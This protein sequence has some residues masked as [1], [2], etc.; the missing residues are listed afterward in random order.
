V[1]PPRGVGQAGVGTRDM[2]R[3]GAERWIGR[4]VQQLAGP[5]GMEQDGRWVPGIA[6]DDQTAADVDVVESPG[7]IGSRKRRLEALTGSAG[8]LPGDASC[9]SGDGQARLVAAAGFHHHM[10]KST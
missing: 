9:C 10:H 3:A 1:S 7:E 8:R 4:L 5:V 6:V 2:V